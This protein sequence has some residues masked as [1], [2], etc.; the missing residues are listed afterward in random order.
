[1]D[2]RANTRWAKQ[3]FAELADG[4]DNAVDGYLISSF[5]SQRSLDKPLLTRGSP[6]N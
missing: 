1:M 4:L 3:L 5:L 2:L 6:P